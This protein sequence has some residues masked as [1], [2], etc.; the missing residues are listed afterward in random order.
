MGDI[1][2]QQVQ[3]MGSDLI[4]IKWFSARILHT[5][6]L[7]ATTHYFL[8]K[9]RFHLYNTQ[10]TQ[11]SSEKVNKFCSI[12]FSNSRRYA[13]L[14]LRK[15]NYNFSCMSALHKAPSLYSSL[16]FSP[17]CTSDLLNYRRMLHCVFFCIFHVGIIAYSIKYFVWCIR[18]MLKFFLCL[19]MG[20]GESDERLCLYNDDDEPWSKSKEEKKMRKYLWI[21][22]IFIRT[23]NKV[24]IEIEREVLS[25]LC[26]FC[27]ILCVHG[28]FLHRILGHDWIEKI[29][30]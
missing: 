23:Q 7:V 10:I 18:R 22:Q 13:Y 14:F 25:V 5:V 27:C 12:F 15:R 11:E 9:T 21:A 29:V 1:F 28:R 2:F 16:P 6:F 8:L 19:K 17:F 30:W 4:W 20:T 26:V 3:R 24:H